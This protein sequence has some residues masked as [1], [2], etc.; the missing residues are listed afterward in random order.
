MKRIRDPR[1]FW[2]GLLF[3]AF[4]A[5]AVVFGRQY[6]FGTAAEMGPGFFPAVLGSLLALMGVIACARSIRSGKAEAAMTAIRARPVLLVLGSVM[7]FAVALPRLGV[8]AASM[9]LVVVSRFAAPGFRWLEVLVFA[10]L[11]TVS[12]ALVFVWG[13][14][15]PMLLWP[16]FLG[17]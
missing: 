1:D 15:M 4:G 12:C 11:L 5:G 10:S 2:S 8:I 14:K 17:G 13:L 16:A 3:I 7:A 6:E 9:L